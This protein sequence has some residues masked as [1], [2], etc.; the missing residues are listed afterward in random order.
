MTVGAKQMD[1]KQSR[2]RPH[3]WPSILAIAVVATLI[4]GGLIGGFAAAP[5][6][7]GPSATVTDGVSNRVAAA[8]P[9]ARATSAV[10]PAGA[11]PTWTNVTGS[12]PN[13]TPPG[14]D[15]VASAFDVADDEVVAFGGCTAVVCPDNYT[16][17]FVNGGWTNITNPF[18]APPPVEGA[19]MDY[20]PN[21]GGA[22]LFGGE[23]ATAYLG[24]TWLFSGGA[25]TNLTS[26]GPGP[27]PRAFGS[28]AFDPDPEVNGSFL[29]GGC[30][31]SCYNDSWAWE[32]WS[33][34][35]PLP[36]SVTPPATSGMAMAFDPVSDYMVLFGGWY[37]CGFLCIGF[38]N[39]TWEFYGGEWWLVHPSG[40]TPLGRDD[41]GMVWDPQ[42][43]A[44]LMYGGGY[45]FLGLFAV[46]ETWTFAA[47]RWS[48]LTGALAGAPPAMS[49]LVLVPDA[50]GGP[51]IA[52]G[53][54]SLTLG[55]TPWTW[56]FEV[57]PSAALAETSST[58]ETTEPIYIHLTVTGGGGPFDIVLGFGDGGSAAAS[59][60]GPTFTVEHTYGV[61]GSYSPSAN[62]SDAAGA[63]VTASGAAIS[64]TS[65]P[66]VVAT[67]TPTTGDAGLPIGFTASTVSP[68]TPPLSYAWEFGDGSNG[69]GAN[70]SH[71]YSAP[72][73]YLVSVNVSDAVLA[74]ANASITV[75]VAASPTAAIELAPESPNTSAPASLFAMVTGGTGP[76][77]YSW[78]FGDGARSSLPSPLHQYNA[79]GSYLVNVWA[80]D[81]VGG[82]AHAT[83]S[84]TV[85][86]GASSGPAGSFA[87]LP[88]WFW[89]GVGALGV[90]AVLGTVL[91][92]RRANS[93]R[94]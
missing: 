43:S 18:D 88:W 1:R 2:V 26:V 57:P 83:L 6:P 72:G 14:A 3:L 69:T 63:S 37:G 44:L 17:V 38:Y 20:D 79:T 62:V 52:F 89:A 80:N 5:A 74:S 30:G 65:G 77:S 45:G 81:S 76:F 86:S 40:P 10:A 49:S 67:A 41:A 42:I 12:D 16:W 31:A 47:D 19:S 46:N 34:W 53:G 54:Y 94:P 87:G 15:G 71:R 82:S 90:V 51:P 29:F 70:T 23:S 60:P 73:S 68:G 11:N 84:V 59:G 75:V 13:A 4:L 39:Q 32:S 58:A 85:Q 27:A 28:M 25:W 56:V 21:M 33:G 78:T 91:L 93:R 9:G 8:V 24:T 7:H 36:S 35:V 61:P 55:Y 50:G 92:L 66:Q 64:V 48:N 22:L